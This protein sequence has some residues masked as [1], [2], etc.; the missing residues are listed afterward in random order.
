[1]IGLDT[2]VLIRWLVR[3]DPERSRKV[4]Q[5]LSEHLEEG[6][7][8]STVVIL[9]V[10]WVCRSVYGF[11]GEEVTAA[12]AELLESAELTMEHENA[13][14]QA[15]EHYSGSAADLEDLLLAQI[16]VENGCRHTVTMD[17]KAARL[18]DMKLL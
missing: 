4:E 13:L 10:W 3:D 12:F 9:E 17:R 16:H 6:F 11:T 5:F 2:N 1:M 7:F 8:I 15:V 18:P 14:R